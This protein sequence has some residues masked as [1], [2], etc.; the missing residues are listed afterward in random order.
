MECRRTIGALACTLS[1]VN[2][3]L[4]AAGEEK[5]QHEIQILDVL[6]DE[7]KRRVR[8][9]FYAVDRNED[10]KLYYKLRPSKRFATWLIDR[11]APKEG[12]QMWFMPWTIVKDLTNLQYDK[13]TGSTLSLADPEEAYDVFFKKEG[14]SKKTKYVGVQIDRQLTPLSDNQKTG[15]KWL[16]FIKDNPVPKCFIVHDY[17]YIARATTPGDFVVPPPKA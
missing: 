9:N 8:Q 11:N 2:S 6:S 1:R 7:V 16:D 15:Q 12:P 10:E 3:S 17:D 4:V 13:K 5:A 14:E